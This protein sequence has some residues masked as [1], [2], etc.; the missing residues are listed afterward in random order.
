MAD[1]EEDDDGPDSQAPA[2]TSE[3]ERSG[4]RYPFYSLEDATEFARAIQK[5]GGNEVS[6]DDLLKFLKLSRT[7]KSWVYKL[8]TAREFQLVERKG[9]KSDARITITDLAKRLLLPGD[10]EELKVTKIAA[11]LTPPLYKKLF[12]RYKGAPVPQVP[13][14]ANL[15]VREHKIVEGVSAQAAEAFIA[16]AKYAGLVN[17][18]DNVLGEPKNGRKSE[19]KP[20]PPDVEKPD[21]GESAP[22]GQTLKVPTDFIAHT[23]PLR[24]DLTVTIPLPQTLTHK[25]VV[26]L[27]KWLDTLV[28][29]D[30]ETT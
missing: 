8:S 18:P 2:A 23:F 29:D 27:H 14:L 1:P 30:E 10:D 16:T 28:F 7:T 4:T 25:D 26:R 6:E 20:P 9:Q 5:S 3:R 24:R 21:A 13:F 19:E 22:T 12:D 11:A 15:L 17:G